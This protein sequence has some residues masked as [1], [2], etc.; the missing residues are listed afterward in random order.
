MDKNRRRRREKRRRVTL[1][2]FLSQAT[3]RQGRKVAGL[4]SYSCGAPALSRVGF[5][6]SGNLEATLKLLIFLAR[7]L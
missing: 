2:H 5:T 3:S 6:V 1:S 7:F 4:V